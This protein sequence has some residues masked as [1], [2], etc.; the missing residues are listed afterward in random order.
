ML[1][2][3]LVLIILIFFYFTRKE[4]F[5]P[6][7]ALNNIASLYNQQTMTVTDF[8]STGNATLNGAT[9]GALNGQVT[10]TGPMNVA[11]DAAFNNMTANGL[12]VQRLGAT[13]ANIATMTGTMTMPG[14]LDVNTV[15]ATNVG[16]D[17]ML[18]QG[19]RPLNYK[20]TEPGLYGSPVGTYQQLQNNTCYQICPPGFLMVGIYNGSDWDHKHPICQRV[21]KKV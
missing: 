10:V 15:L 9:I 19:G 2:I 14:T 18:Y 6:D 13:A 3:V 5:T 1:I 21:V 7:E 20:C 8:V 4:Y 16:N 17:N 11:G 12:N